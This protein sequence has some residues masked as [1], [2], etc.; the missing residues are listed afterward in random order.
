M[1]NSINLLFDLLKDKIIN[2][3]ITDNDDFQTSTRSD[4]LRLEEKV[5]IGDVLLIQGRS[6]ISRV[7]SLLTRSIWTH[8]VLYIGEIQHIQDPELKGILKSLFS[9]PENVKLIIESLLDKGVTIAPLSEYRLDHIRICRPSGLP[10]AHAEQLIRAATQFIGEKYNTQQ[11]FDLAK[12]L[13][14][15][16]IF[17]SSWRTR[18]FYHRPGDASRLIC[19][20][21]IVEAFHA[22]KYPI[23]PIVHKHGVK[24]FEFVRRNPRLFTPCDFDYSPFFD[25]IKYPIIEFS[26]DIPYTQLKWNEEGIISNDKKGIFLAP[27]NDK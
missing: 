15:W 6:R 8:S 23:L 18:L 19:S 20:T 4:F 2:W 5:R 11:I 26:D 1:S 10:E 16:H 22:I 27:K 13:L 3:L 21:L 12:L 14:P 9:G 7:I 25:I 17:P 24:G